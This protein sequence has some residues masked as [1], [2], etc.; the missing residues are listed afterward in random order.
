MTHYQHVKEFLYQEEADFLY[1]KLLYE[2][3]WR[4]VKYYKPERGLV[5]T[6]RLTWV[7]G[8]HQDDFYP[9]DLPAKIFPNQIPVFINELKELVEEYTSQKYN[10]VLFSLYR[11]GEDSISPHSDDELFLGS[12]PT[13]ASISIGQERDFTLTNKHTR[14]KNTFSLNHGDLFIM[15]NDCQKN[16]LHS[17]PKCKNMLLNPRISLTFRKSLTEAGSKNYYKY[18]FLNTIL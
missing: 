4:Q 3:P 10:F 16:Y 14:E 9:I 7:A 15:K 2:I 6:P 17:V 12:N 1:Q 5:T 11:D 13:I 18:N 8:F